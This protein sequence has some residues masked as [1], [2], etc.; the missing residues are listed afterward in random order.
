MPTVYNFEDEVKDII[1]NDDW[2]KDVILN[3]DEDE[4]LYW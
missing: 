1:Y 2:D 3:E 4:V